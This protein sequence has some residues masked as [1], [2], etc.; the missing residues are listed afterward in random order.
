MPCKGLETAE[1]PIAWTLDGRSLIC[2]RNAGLAGDVFIIEIATGRRTPLWRLATDDRA[3]ATPLTAIVVTP[4]GK[5]YAFS[6]WRNISD[7]YLIDGLK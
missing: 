2:W 1:S 6:Y 5:S 4:D 7:L 3:G